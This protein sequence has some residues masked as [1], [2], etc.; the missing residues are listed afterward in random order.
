MKSIL[1]LFFISIATFTFAQQDTTVTVNLPHKQ[2]D[3]KHK[4]PTGEEN[5][6]KIAPLGFV[7]GTFPVY[8]ERVISDFFTVQGGVGITSRN[9]VRNTF[10]SIDP[11]TPVY[12]WS[13]NYS[14]SDLADNTLE[15]GNRKPN[16]GF[17]L[18]VQPR[19]YFNSEAPD[20]SFMSISYDFY[21]Y[22]FSIPGIVYNSNLNEYKH[23][24]SNK[25]E[26][27]NISDLMATFGYHDVYDHLSIDYSVGMGI[28]NVR[29]IKYYYGIENF[30]T[31]PITPIEGFADYKQT[32]FNF[33]LG[34]K[35]G[36]HF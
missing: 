19:I 5:T 4:K 8:Y 17:L 22:N 30:G 1:L 11:I 18:S 25:K 27:E 3:K 21:R 20:E 31:P 28:R 23:T 7:S 2:Y 29:G 24:G 35:V 36:Y 15:M 9:Y 12:P 6:I 13:N 26:H 33:N 32:T 10:Q 14:L 34:I 16:L